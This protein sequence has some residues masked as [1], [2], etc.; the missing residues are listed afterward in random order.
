MTRVTFGVSAPSFVANMCVKQNAL[1]FALAYP[2]AAKAVEDSFYVDDGLAGADCCKEATQLYQ[3]LQCLFEKGGFLLRKWSSSKVEHIDP[4]LCDQH[5]LHT[6]SGDDEYT[7]TLGVEWNSSHDHFR[8][9][10]T[11][12][13]PQELTKRNLTSEIAKVFDVL[14]WIA[15]VTVKAKIML[16]RL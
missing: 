5:S 10:I 12:L 13:T 15:P 14:G 2:L 11:E 7:K 3:Q 8:L 4:S 16:Q 1:D 6:F 9:V